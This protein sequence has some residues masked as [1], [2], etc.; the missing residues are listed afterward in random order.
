MEKVWSEKKSRKVIGDV[1][2]A[3]NINHFTDGWILIGQF[4]IHDLDIGIKVS[5]GII[6]KPQLSQN[7][8]VMAIRKSIK[9]KS[10]REVQA[11][12]QVIKNQ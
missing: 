2:T 12:C 3:A 10:G 4:L 1:G 9:S 5:H 7:G 8:I 6:L 11:I